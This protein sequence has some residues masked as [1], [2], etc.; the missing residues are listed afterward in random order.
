MYTALH[1]A[2]QE[3]HPEICRILLNHHAN[4]NIQGGDQNVAALHIAA[5]R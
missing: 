3:N 2:T 1:L 4:P 5:H